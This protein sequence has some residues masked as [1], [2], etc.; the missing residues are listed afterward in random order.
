MPPLW[1]FRD[2]TYQEGREEGRQERRE[3]GAAVRLVDSVRHVMMKSGV[4]LNEVCDMIGATAE[5][6]EAARKLVG[7]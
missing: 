6:Y 5:Q 3:I 2:D 4:S 1:I 7:K